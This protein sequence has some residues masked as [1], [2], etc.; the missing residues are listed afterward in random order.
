ML[1]GNAVVWRSSEADLI[2]AVERA[3]RSV[4]GGSARWVLRT[5]YARGWGAHGGICLGKRFILGILRMWRSWKHG[6][7]CSTR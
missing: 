7:S 1:H 2:I 6:P 4:F 3:R 5:R